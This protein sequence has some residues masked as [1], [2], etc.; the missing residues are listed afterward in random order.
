[1]PGESWLVSQL[2]VGRDTVRAALSYLEEE[3]LLLPAGHGKRRRIVMS[4]ESFTG[5][6]RVSILLHSPSDRQD[7]MVHEIIHQLN[8]RGHQVTVAPKSLTELGMNVDR[9]SRMVPEVETDAWIVC[10]APQ[11]VLTWF[12]GRSTPTF[13]L[14]GRF[15]NISVAAIGPDKFPAYQTAIR[16]LAELG[17]RRV[18]LLV[19]EFARKP[20]PGPLILRILQEMEV[21]GMAVG[22]YALPDWE[23][24]PVGLRRCLDQLFKLTPPT[25]LFMEEAHEFFAIRIDLAERGI[26]CPRDVSLICTD[27]HPAFKW[28]EPSVSCIRWSMRPIVRRIVRWADHVANGKD[29]AKKDYSKAK[30]VEGGT[31]GPARMGR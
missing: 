26:H 31:I 4:R 7:A 2:Q 29:D 16:R 25:A 1:M 13:A 14:F 24:N 17:H 8:L 3:G 20:E 9:V 18:V 23:V 19:P 22:P 5:N 6:F 15:S 30:F 27:D 21:H 11:E 12:S 10:A 28:C